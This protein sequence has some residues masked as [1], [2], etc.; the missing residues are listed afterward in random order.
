MNTQSF[1]ECQHCWELGLLEGAVQDGTI[2]CKKCNLV[3]KISNFLQFELNKYVVGSQG[4]LSWYALI[5][6]ALALTASIVSIFV[7]IYY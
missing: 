3:L 4:R 1:S 6:S 2:K 5:I 7:E